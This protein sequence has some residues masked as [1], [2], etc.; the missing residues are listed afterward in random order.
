MNVHKKTRTIRAVLF[1]FDGTLTVGTA[2]DFKAIRRE[3]GCPE[4]T[5]LLEYIEAIEPPEARHA[6]AE[7]LAFYER[8]GASQSYPARGAVE[9]LRFLRGR[10][11]PYGILTR[12]SRESV[13]TSMANF[14]EGCLD[15]FR[16]VI[17]RDDEYE[18]KPSSAGVL[19]AAEVFDVAPSEITVIGDYL[20]DVQAGNNAGALTVF[21]DAGEN[22]SISRNSEAYRQAVEEADYTVNNLEQFREYIDMYLPLLPGKVPNRMLERIF[23]EIDLHDPSIIVTPG[24]GEDTA[25]VRLSG[26][27]EV[28]VLKSDPVTFVGKGLGRYAVTVNANDAATS[29]ADP[30]WF[31]ADLLLPRGVTGNDARDLIV[32]TALAAEEAGIT[33]CGGHTEVTGAVTR[34][35]LSGSLI[36]TVAENG[37]IQKRNMREGDVLLM[38]KT[39]GCEGTGILSSEFAGLLAKN[40]V[41]EKDIEDGRVF[42]ERISILPEAKIAAETGG[43]TAM[44]DVTEGGI[45]TA[46]EELSAAGG[47]VLHVDIDAIAVSPV[48]ARICNALELDPLGLIGSGCLLIT[49]GTAGVEALESKLGSAGIESARIGRVGKEGTGVITEGDSGPSAWPRFETD[50]ITK[51]Y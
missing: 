10:K 22:S 13:N 12:N 45:A 31:L 4:G 11:I 50:E 39:A 32:E 29:G 7:Q 18:V 33:L 24:V 48:T 41:S 16:T 1:D 19:R 21:L 9:L 43:V 5:S 14:P 3:I 28:L 26:G 47:N 37:L 6:A 15:T 20:Y 51:L 27:A 42:T 44:H 17:C 38:T 30:K 49:F 40:G 35:V 23:A 8:Q 36:G 2:L 25:A 34:A 46:L